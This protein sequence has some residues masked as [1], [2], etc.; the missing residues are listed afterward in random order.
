MEW[1]TRLVVVLFL[2]YDVNLVT[3]IENVLMVLTASTLWHTGVLYLF[4]THI[5]GGGGGHQCKKKLLN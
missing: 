5:G 4:C 1:D 3:Y 2:L